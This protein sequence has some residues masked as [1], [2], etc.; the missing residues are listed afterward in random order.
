MMIAWKAWQASEDYDNAKRW[1]QELSIKSNGPK[2]AA[3]TAEHPHLE[4]SLW[5]AFVAGWNARASENVDA[6]L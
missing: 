1:A 3:W 4:G 5:A 2:L 6:P